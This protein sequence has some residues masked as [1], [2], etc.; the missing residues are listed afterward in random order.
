MRDGKEVTL[1]EIAEPEKLRAGKSSELGKSSK[2][3]KSN[4]G[5]LGIRQVLEFG[6]SWNSASLGNPERVLH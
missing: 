2:L 5:N 3:G 4:P 1:R 6:K